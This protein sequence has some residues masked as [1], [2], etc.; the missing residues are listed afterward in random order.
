M[1]PT[2]R[3]ATALILLGLAGSTL[4]QPGRPGGRGIEAGP[5]G[6]GRLAPPEA[7]ERMLERFDADG[8]GELSETEREAARE[9]I[10]TE[11]ADRHEAA[12][13]KLLERFDDN[14][15]G[16]LDEAERA[17]VRATI[18]PMLR[19]R[20]QREGGRGEGRH[21]RHAF[22]RHVLERFDADGDGTLNET[23]RAAAKAFAE[24]KKAELIERFDADGDGTLTGDEREAA[25]AYV[26]ERRT[27]DANRDGTVDELDVQALSDRVATTG[28][29]PDINADGTGDA[30]DV[31]ELI[32]RIKAVRD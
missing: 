19:E 9:T 8:N 12:K 15:D 24:Q 21:H 25:R 30:A 6:E 10:R 32:E 17:E 13:A 5:R 20:M 26:R 31:A 18:G 11:H 16:E 28:E 1:N 3:I 7:R 2:A 27:L 14:G 29:I 4:G 22:K 23:E